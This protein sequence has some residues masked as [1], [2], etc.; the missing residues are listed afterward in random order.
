MDALCLSECGRWLLVGSTPPP[1]SVR[2]LKVNVDTGALSPVWAKPGKSRDH[3]WHLG[4][5]LPRVPAVIVRTGFGPSS[6]V[7]GL[8]GV[9]SIVLPEQAEEETQSRL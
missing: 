9:S 6:I 2:A 8:L 4:C 3:C 1:G 7:E 5:I